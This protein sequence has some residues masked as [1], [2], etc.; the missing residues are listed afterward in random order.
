MRP[1]IGSCLSQPQ[2]ATAAKVP[3][4]VRGEFFNLAGE[5]TL[6]VVGSIDEAPLEP[7]ELFPIGKTY[8]N[9]LC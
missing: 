7:L 4:P 8:G 1:V 5:T 6:I 3:I 9:R 2:L